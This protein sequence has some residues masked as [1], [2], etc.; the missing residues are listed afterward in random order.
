[1]LGIIAS[2]VGFIGFDCGESALAFKRSPLQPH[3]QDVIAVEYI[4]HSYAWHINIILKCSLNMGLVSHRGRVNDELQ[5]ACRNGRH[6][7]WC[8][9]VAPASRK[10]K[11]QSR[12]WPSQPVAFSAGIVIGFNHACANNGVVGEPSR[13]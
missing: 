10:R 11:S 3:G 5:L 8:F 13:Q 1:M 2:G 7:Q 12:R 9:Q 6:G 4:A